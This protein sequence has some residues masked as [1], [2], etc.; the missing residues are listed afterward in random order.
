MGKIATTVEEQI[1]LLK[2][3]GMVLDCETEKIKKM[4]NKIKFLLVVLI[5]TL[6]LSCKSNRDN[7]IESFMKEDGY[8]YESAC[9]ACDEEASAINHFEQNLKRNEEIS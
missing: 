7:C 1:A 5:L 4:K 2:A 3:R 8:D 6:T 9:E